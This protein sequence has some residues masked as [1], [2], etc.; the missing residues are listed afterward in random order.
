VLVG[1]SLSTG[2][3]VAVK[4]IRKD[5]LLDEVERRDLELE[6]DV[7]NRIGV[8][9]LNCIWLLDTFED[10]RYVYLVSASNISLG[11]ATSS[12]GDAKSSLALTLPR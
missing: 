10:S 8:G 11:D 2:D 4:R 5:K 7:M 12:L 9:S 1:T 3:K 6:V